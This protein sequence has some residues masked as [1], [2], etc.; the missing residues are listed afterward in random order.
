MSKKKQAQ[1]RQVKAEIA[2][3]RSKY[4]L[5]EGLLAWGLPM[6]VFYCF[7]AAIIHSLLASISFA[8]ALRALFP[9]TFGLGVIAF[10]CGGY[11][12]GRYKWRK[13]LE[14]AGPK[15]QKKK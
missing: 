9:L 6:F 11:F 8:Q 5:R 15:Y 10:A 13:L 14:K 2:G 7:F 4:I 1:R 3:G 12:M